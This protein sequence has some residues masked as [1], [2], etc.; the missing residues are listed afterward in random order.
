M[1]SLSLSIIK[2]IADAKTYEEIA[3]IKFSHLPNNE[4]D[5]VQEFWND[6]RI[7]I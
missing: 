4:Y 6:K 7:Y 2:Q 1:E 3:S 5:I